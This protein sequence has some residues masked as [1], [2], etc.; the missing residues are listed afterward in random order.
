MHVFSCDLHATVPIHWL[1]QITIREGFYQDGTVPY[2]YGDI[3]QPEL[4]LTTPANVR[5][6]MSAD[7]IHKLLENADILITGAGTSAYISSAIAAAW[8]R[9]KIAITC[10]EV[11]YLGKANS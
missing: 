6:A 8:L 2:P 5:K 9:A 4:W 3:A 10:N 7:Q 1:L 11:G